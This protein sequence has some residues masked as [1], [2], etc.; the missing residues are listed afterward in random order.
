MTSTESA[1]E[2]R[3]TGMARAINRADRQEPEFSGCA[4]RFLAEFAKSA[5]KPF[6]IEEVSRAYAEKN[7]PPP[8][9]GRAWGSIVKNAARDALIRR[10]GFGP[11]KS[12]NLAPK[13][14]WE[15]VRPS[16]DGGAA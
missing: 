16:S 6:L 11:A 8:P 7:L 2:R 9:D 15:L 4:S 3:D 13:P 5:R 10:A 14:L 12:S 1:K